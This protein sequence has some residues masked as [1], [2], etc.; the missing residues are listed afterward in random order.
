MYTEIRDLVL[1]DLP[2]PPKSRPTRITVILAE[3][4]YR[5]SDMDIMESAI[6]SAISGGKGDIIVAP[7]YSYS[8]K[9]GP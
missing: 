7:E 5:S 1:E 6:L 9:S 3:T 4:G 2:I 8:P